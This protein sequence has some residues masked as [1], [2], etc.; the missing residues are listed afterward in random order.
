MNIEHI[1]HRCREDGDC[2]IWIGYA[3][4]GAHPRVSIDG[5]LMSVRRVVWSEKNGGIP[6]RMV[7]RNTCG[8]GLC[9]SPKC[10]ELTTY[11]RIRTG[12]KKGA[13]V[14]MKISQKRR[15]RS[16]VTIE[17][18]RLIRASDLPAAHFDEMFGKSRGWAGSIRRGEFWKDISSPFAGLGAR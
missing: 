1:K 11:S 7:V 2:W 16:N 15:A 13:D 4:E 12:I 9:V 8:N 6:A 3:V 17:D 10:M 18:V 5:K 14:G